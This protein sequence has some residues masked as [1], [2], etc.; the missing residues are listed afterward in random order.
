MR[1]ANQRENETIGEYI[2]RIHHT[3]EPCP[4]LTTIENKIVVSQIESLWELAT[5][6]KQLNKY[7]KKDM[8]AILQGLAFQLSA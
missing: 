7:Q 5:S 6:R 1:Y 4:D 8:R 2:H 3:D